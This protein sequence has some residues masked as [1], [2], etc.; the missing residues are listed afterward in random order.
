MRSATHP[1][2]FSPQKG[3]TWKADSSKRNSGF[4][5][6]DCALPPLQRN[7]TKTNHNTNL[8]QCLT[9]CG[10]EGCVDTAVTLS[11]GRSLSVSFRSRSRCHRRNLHAGTPISVGVLFFKRRH[12]GICRF[13]SNFNI[14]VR[15]QLFEA[16]RAVAVSVQPPK[17]Q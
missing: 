13:S 6:E 12:L 17:T 4:L 5:S 8:K 11:G 14:P 7:Q 2:C 3:S 15:L 10:P 9:R 16:Q 1:N